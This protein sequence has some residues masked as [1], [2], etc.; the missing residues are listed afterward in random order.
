M[1]R[2][3]IRGVVKVLNLNKVA[4]S[5][6][7][8]RSHFGYTVPWHIYPVASLSISTVPVH[9]IFKL[10]KERLSGAFINFVALLQLF[11]M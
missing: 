9:F 3:A 8:E 7:E 10:M 4:L 11:R 5:Y 2:V 1:E 6:L